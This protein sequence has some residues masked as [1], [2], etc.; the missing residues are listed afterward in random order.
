MT[1]TSETRT[2][3]P[4]AMFTSNTPE[5]YT[6]PEIIKAVRELF[7]G[8]IDL[9]PCSNSH[10]DPNVPARE[11]FTREDDGLSRAWHGRVYMNPPYVRGVIDT[12]IEKVR[13][14]YESGRVSEA[15]VL[16]AA[17]TDTQWYRILSPKYPRCEIEGRLEFIPGPGVT[18]SG[19]AGYP[20]VVYYLGP[21]MS[22][23]VEVFDK[24]G[25]IVV[26]WSGRVTWRCRYDL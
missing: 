11:H 17:R 12:W 25:V 8:T 4:R 5:W 23:F 20:S 10:A 21:N 15:A 18:R 22:R 1:D 3:G 26:P 14:E 13:E 24:L 2:P 19:K 9:D 16:V 6:P 7:G